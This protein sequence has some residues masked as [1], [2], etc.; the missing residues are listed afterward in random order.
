MEI[1]I[2]IKKCIEK[3]KILDDDYKSYFY[4]LVDLKIDLKN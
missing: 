2:D 1:T 3:D 4:K